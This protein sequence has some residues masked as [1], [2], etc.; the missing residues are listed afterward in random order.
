MCSAHAVALFVCVVAALALLPGRAAA[1]GGAKTVTVTM[2]SDGAVVAAVSDPSG[3]PV[4][5]LS[6]TMLA[7]SDTGSIIGPR[8]LTA[9]ADHPGRYVTGPSVLPAGSWTVTVSDPAGTRTTTVLTSSGPAAVAKPNPRHP[10]PTRTTAGNLAADN[11]SWTNR[12]PGVVLV[13]IGVGV[14][15]AIVLA[16]RRHP[17]RRAAR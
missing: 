6:L 12:L 15:A 5:G 14:L 7:R 13:V 11:A 9:E 3:A 17:R 16:S 8:P 10:Q 4:T 2:S 1:A